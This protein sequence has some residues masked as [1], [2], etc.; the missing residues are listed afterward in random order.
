M[1]SHRFVSALG[2]VGLA[3]YAARVRTS[4]LTWGATPGEAHAR[5]PGDELM[6]LGIKQRVERLASTGLSRS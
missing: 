2:A 1:R 4:V 6:L 3:L 5:L